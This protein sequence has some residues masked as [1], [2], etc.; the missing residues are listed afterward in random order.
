MNFHFILMCMP[1]LSTCIS[2][3]HLFAGAWGG[4]MRTSQFPGTGAMD[5]CEA[6]CGYWELNPGPL[7]EQQVLLIHWAISSIPNVF[8]V[9]H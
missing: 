7:Q 6:Q 4:Q 3:H 5:G 8:K 2:V 1:A 9:L